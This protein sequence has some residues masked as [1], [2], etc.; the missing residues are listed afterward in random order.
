MGGLLSKKKQQ[1]ASASASNDHDS[2]SKRIQAQAQVSSKDR[3]ILELKNARDRLKRY[4]QRL[5]TE[6]QVLHES[7]RQLLQADKRVRSF[8]GKRDGY[9]LIFIVCLIAYLGKHT[10]TREACAETEEV[11]G[12]TDPASR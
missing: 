1:K 5:D 6:A 11:Q 9:I 8:T 7:A 10:G 4:Q 3:A 12:A 2:N